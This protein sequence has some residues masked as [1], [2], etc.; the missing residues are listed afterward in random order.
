MTTTPQAVRRASP[1]TRRTA[2]PPD[3][4]RSLL[5]DAE[6][7]RLLDRERHTAARPRRL[8]G[9]ARRGAARAVPPDGARPPL[10]HPGHRPDQAGPARRL[11]VLAGPGGVPGRRGPR[12]ARQRLGLPHLP[13]ID[14][15]GRPGHRPGR[16]AHPAA[17]RLALRL[18]PDRASAPRRSAPR[19]PPSACTPPGWRTARRTRGATP[20]RWPSSATAPPARATSTRRSTSPPCSRRR[21]SSSCRTTGYAISVPLSRQTAAPSLAYKGVGYG[22][23]SEQV[24]GNDPVAV[25]A[26]LTR[27]VAPRPRRQRAVPGRGAHLPDG[28]RTPTPTTPPATATAPRSTPGATA[29]RSPGWRP[30]CAPA[31]CSTT[32]RSP[33]S[34]SEAEAY[35]ADLRTR[36]NERARPS[37]R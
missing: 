26:V 21:W 5:P 7:V 4:A 35:A 18:R 17:R 36:M 24:D 10:R 34:P 1:R 30:T 23:P 32:R 31:A 22:V 13:R 12:A 19:S 20:S 11:P 15:A 29:T 33:R 8:P 6:P 28:A 16:G 9:A 2:T 25:L 14:G 37:T 3:P 27:A